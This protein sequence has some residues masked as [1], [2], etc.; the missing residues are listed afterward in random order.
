MFIR[1]GLQD[2]RNYIGTRPMV[3]KT[4]GALLVLSLLLA[5]ALLT[6][7]SLSGSPRQGRAR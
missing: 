7:P 3:A 4:E 2:I 1:Y 6:G 5:F